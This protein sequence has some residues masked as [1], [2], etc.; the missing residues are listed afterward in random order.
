MAKSQ[1]GI[2]SK[3]NHMNIMFTCIGRRVSLLRSFADATKQL[4]LR[5]RFFGTDT[6]EL[7]PALQLCD[8]AFLVNPVTHRF[9]LNQLLNIIRDN[10]IKLL[11]PT[12]DLDLKLLA[13]NAGT[14]DEA[15]CKILV[16]KPHI[17]DICQDKRKTYR[18]LM[19]NGFDTPV[20]VSVQ[21]AL[22]DRHLRWP[23]FIKPWDG[24]A[25]RGT[26]IA[27]NREELVFYTKR[28]PNPIIQEFIDG[29][30]YTCDVY[31][32]FGM[33]VRCVV[34]RKRIETRSGEVSKG[35]AV[36]N[37]KI[38]DK[39]RELVEKL[40]AGPGVITI[41][42]FLNGHGKIKFIEINPRFGGGAPLSIKAGANF[43]KWILQELMG[44]R[45]KIN[46]DGFEDGLIMLRYDSEVWL[47]TGKN[48]EGKK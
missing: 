37:L 7:S 39:C 28:I 6:T 27:K 30:E 18:F 25:S 35:Q 15:G 46:F 44:Q 3:N 5:A 41:Q 11:V 34:P 40:G 8:K 31:V 17:I 16:S 36:K 45:P 12:V 21:Q 26:A 23:C 4:H 43:P 47:K 33:K 9:Y 10:Q 19:N 24:Y 38:M 2:G 42:L 13:E 32:D 48:T 1:I 22:A 20:T 29:T 14:F